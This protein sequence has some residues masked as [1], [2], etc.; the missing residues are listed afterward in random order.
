MLA[1]PVTQRVL[2]DQ[3]QAQHIR[4]EPVAGS[5][6]RGATIAQRIEHLDLQVV[7][8]PALAG[9]PP[10][11]LAPLRVERPGL[12]IQRFSAQATHQ[13]GM[14][15][16]RTAAIRH[17]NAALQQGIEQVAGGGNG[18]PLLTHP[19]LRHRHPPRPPRN[20]YVRCAWP[21]RAPDRRVAAPHPDHRAWSARSFRWTSS[22]YPP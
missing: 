13:A 8:D 1:G 18:Q 9:Q 19:K 7:D 12:A 14:A 16:A 21:G 17:G 3:P 6:L 22:E 4:A 2:R 11:L 5:D 15:T 10:A 20:G